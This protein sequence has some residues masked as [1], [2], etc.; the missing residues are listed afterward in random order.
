[1]ALGF[2]F[3]LNTSDPLLVRWSDRFFH[4]IDLGV[5]G[6]DSDIIARY[7][8][9][10]VNVISTFHECIG[11]VL[12]PEKGTVAIGGYYKYVDLD[13]TLPE[14]YSRT[15]RVDTISIP[16]GELSE[17]ALVAALEATFTA[18]REISRGEHDLSRWRRR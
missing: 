5:R 4:G 8:S 1:M 12:N 11:A 16:L 3:T 10:N 18:V 15:K 17:E 7:H 6:N 9:R 13:S 2:V 14:S